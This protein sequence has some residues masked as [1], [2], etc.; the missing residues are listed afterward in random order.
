MLI[1]V[2]LVTL[3]G[4]AFLVRTVAVLLAVSSNK[5]A[6]DYPAPQTSTN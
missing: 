5:K 1:T 6:N 2:T 4:L 3:G